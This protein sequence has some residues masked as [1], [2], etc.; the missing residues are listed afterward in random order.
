MILKLVLSMCLSTHT[1]KSYSK[2]YNQYLKSIG[3]ALWD[4]LMVTGDKSRDSLVKYSSVNNLEEA[5]IWVRRA[6]CENGGVHRNTAFYWLTALLPP[7]VEA[8]LCSTIAG[9][10]FESPLKKIMSNAFL[11]EH[12]LLVS[13]VTQ[14][15]F[16]PDIHI[17]QF[18][19][20]CVCWAWWRLERSRGVST[21]FGTILSPFPHFSTLFSPLSLLFFPFFSF[22]SSLPLQGFI[23]SKLASNLIGRQ[24][25]MILNFLSSW[26]HLL[27]A[28]VT[29]KCYQA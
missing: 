23:N 28:E 16:K 9:L 15:Q 25:R 8:I 13:W 5:I 14:S 4:F 19:T 10:H 26:P 17:L 24:L 21:A 22:F 18:L 7:N 3:K 11:W 6:G 1:P 20:L 2:H 29:G 27:S 12:P